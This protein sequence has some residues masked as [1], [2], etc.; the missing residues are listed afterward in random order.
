M[1]Q[2]KVPTPTATM[3]TVAGGSGG[4]RSLLQSP[5][6]DNKTKWKQLTELYTHACYNLNILTTGREEE[7]RN[8]PEEED[9]AGG[10]PAE[11]RQ[12]PE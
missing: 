10:S 6:K 5:E 2:I 12:S 7:C 1:Y 11:W 9:W 3:A 8:L 4:R